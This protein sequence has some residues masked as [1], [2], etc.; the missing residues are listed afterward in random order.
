MINLLNQNKKIIV[1]TDLD[2]ILSALI[3]HNIL[4]C[5]V[6]GFCNSSNT[7]WIDKRKTLSIYDCVYI[8]MFVPLENVGCIDQHIIS[9]NE[10]HQHNI[11]KLKNKFNPNLDNPRF[12]LPD[13]SYYLKYP[14]GT[15]HYI[16]AVLESKGIKIELE[17]NN[18]LENISLIDILL[19]ADDAMQTSVSSNY[20]SNAKDW[21][22]W[23]LK[24]S[25]NGSTIKA[26]TDYL[27]HLKTN[28][29]ALV[30]KSITQKLTSAP[31]NCV[32]P[33]GGY[34]SIANANGELNENVKLYINFLASLSKMKTFDLNLTLEP[35]IGKSKRISLNESQQV[36]LIEKGTI[37]NEKIFSYAFVKSS[38]KTESFS[39]TVMPK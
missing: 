29:V 17:L 23:M 24:L 21:W 10:K 37:G 1:N 18:Q 27:S 38:I 14:F 22:Q 32:S 33:D 5:E 31:F 25:N 8:D 28:E 30:K 2:G 20:V 7:V 4:N 35:I 9:V 36:E 26:F 6:V 39:Y 13:K 11:K 12:H 19:R 3:L 34:K 16:I 15:I